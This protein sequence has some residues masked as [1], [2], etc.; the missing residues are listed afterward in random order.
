MF[1]LTTSFFCLCSYFLNKV[2]TAIS[3]LAFLS[4]K[5]LH[6]QKFSAGVVLD[7]T[8]M[9]ASSFLAPV[10]RFCLQISVVPNQAVT[11]AVNI[12][13]CNESI[14]AIFCHQR[15]SIL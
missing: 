15:C 5:A 10:Y 13:H 11:H 4:A 8:S 3:V 14:F 1:A 6:V 9:V 2:P 7:E 12:N